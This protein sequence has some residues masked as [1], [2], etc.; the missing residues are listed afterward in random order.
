MFVYHL[1]SGNFS[2]FT[3]LSNRLGGTNIFT[4]HARCLE[5]TVYAAF[6]TARAQ[7]TTY[8]HYLS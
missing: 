2:S 8:G 1:E 5:S 7:V 6:M 4:V 3:V